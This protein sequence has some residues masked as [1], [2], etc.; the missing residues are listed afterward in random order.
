MRCRTL[1]KRPRNGAAGN[2][3]PGR[4]L[5]A[6]VSWLVVGIALAF[7]FSSD[8]FGAGWVLGQQSQ[9]ATGVVRPGP[10][11]L[12]RALSLRDYNTRIVVLGT[13]LLGAAAGVIGTFA[14][15]RK[16]ALLGDAL[17]HATLPGIAI[18]FMLSSQKHLGL[19]L[20]GATIA[21]VLGVIVVLGMRMVPRIKED[22]AIGVVLS[23]FFGAGMVLFSLI[24][25]MRTGDEAGLQSF[26]YGQAAAMLGRDAM[27]IATVA[28]IVVLGSAL[29]FK[30]FRLVCFDRSYAGAQGWAVNWIDL[31]MMCLVVLITVVGL[32]AVGLILVVA[33]LI[34]PAA[35]ARFWTDRLTSM[36][37]LA[38]V[39]GAA[40]CYVGA[41]LS[42]LMP[43][44][45]TGAVIVIAAGVVFAISM[46]VSPHR[47][48]LASMVRQ[49]SLA[50]RVARQH[51]LRA[52]AE[53]EEQRG[54]GTVVRFDE[55][56]R[57]RTWR[58]NRLNRLIRRAGGGGLVVAEPDS[59]FRLT[60]H[61]R[62]E[63]RRIL[64]N[65]RLWEMYLI[66]YA[67]IAPSHVDRDA[68]EVEHILPPA[69]VTELEQAIAKA[70]RIPPSPHPLETVV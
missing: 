45:P 7:C 31:L 66:K 49:W 69:L 35:A 26:I 13:T 52:M 34:I 25:Q 58:A 60:S 29:F 40:S 65:H 68:D 63:A 67:D 47:G 48:L 37:L 43:R 36:V 38:G 2:D 9:T 53:F 32:Q 70:G 6:P 64:R 16:R 22:A 56:L 62:D 33:L 41:T 8:V 17:S 55:L 42:A 20:L 30:E 39:F 15:L 61:G 57:K 59:S 44:L 28:V 23:V 5:T 46:L 50:R 11:E 1:K 54:A 19:L 24:Q 14:Y 3:G 4:V 12:I 21:G 27:L 10:A 18:A 51:L